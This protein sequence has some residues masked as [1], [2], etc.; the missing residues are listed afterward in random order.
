[1]IQ[2]A[3]FMFANGTGAARMMSRRTARPYYTLQIFIGWLKVASGW[4]EIGALPEPRP[5]NGR[6]QLPKWFRCHQ[7]NGHANNPNRAGNIA[8]IRQIIWIDLDPIGCVGGSQRHIS[9]ADWLIA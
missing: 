8:C 5:D 1:M 9:P 6:I 4:C 3:A 7:F 2:R